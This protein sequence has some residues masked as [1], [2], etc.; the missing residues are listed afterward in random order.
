MRLNFNVRGAGLEV[1]TILLLLIYSLPL[2]FMLVHPAVIKAKAIW[3]SATVAWFVFALLT[4]KSLLEHPPSD[5][6][7]KQ[8]ESWLVNG[9]VA[10]HLVAYGGAWLA[11]WAFRKATPS[12]KP[13]KPPV[14]GRA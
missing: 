6:S 12:N 1:G 14:S 2:L 3:V 7:P 11:Y 8:M 13:F 5:L 9:G 4:E 10:V